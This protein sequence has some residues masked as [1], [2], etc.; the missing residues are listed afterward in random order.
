MKIRNWNLLTNCKKPIKLTTCNKPIKLTTCNKSACGVLCF[1]YL[2]SESKCL[3][4]KCKGKDGSY[5]RLVSLLAK[6]H[7]VQIIRVTAPG[8]FI[9]IG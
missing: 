4:L 1:V 7:F 6:M 3:S 2:K 5:K 9:A 8:K